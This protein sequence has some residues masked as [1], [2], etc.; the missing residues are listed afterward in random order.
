MAVAVSSDVHAKA[1]IFSRIQEDLPKCWDIGVDRW[2][3]RCCRSV[4]LGHHLEQLSCNQLQDAPP[5]NPTLAKQLHM[6][7]IFCQ[8]T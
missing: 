4:L 1:T 8:S 3:W 5:H 2:V 7:S 6:T